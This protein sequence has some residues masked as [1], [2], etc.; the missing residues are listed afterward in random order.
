MHL[1]P[2]QPLGTVYFGVGLIFVQVLGAFIAEDNFF[3]ALGV[4]QEGGE[5][6]ARLMVSGARAQPSVV[7]WQLSGRLQVSVPRGRHGD[8]YR[9]A[10]NSIP[11]TEATLGLLQQCPTVRSNTFLCGNQ[12]DCR[13]DDRTALLRSQSRARLRIR[14]MKPFDFLPQRQRSIIAD[15]TSGDQGVASGS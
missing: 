9:Q 10:F 4:G 15:C 11:P 6:V 12:T 5:T 1:P 2:H 7:R 14:D 3:E 13:L 8:S